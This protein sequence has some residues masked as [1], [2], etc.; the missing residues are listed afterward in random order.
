MTS[1]G[2]STLS[3]LLLSG[4]A[5]ATMEILIFDDFQSSSYFLQ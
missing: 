4:S 3:N 2:I 5:M 1:E